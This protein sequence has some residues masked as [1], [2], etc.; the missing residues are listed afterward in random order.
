MN[1]GG[2]G[3]KLADF[4][5]QCKVSFHASAESVAS[6]ERLRS[7]KG[8]ALPSSGLKT[9]EISLRN[10]IA[11][12]LLI[13][14]WDAWAVHRLLQVKDIICCQIC[15]PGKARCRQFVGWVVQNLREAWGGVSQSHQANEDSELLLVLSEASRL[16]PQACRLQQSA[17]ETLQLRLL[18]PTASHQKSPS[19]NVARES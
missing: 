9:P 1:W 15:G 10:T 17:Q 7:Q 18:V 11:Q 2:T 4:T 12:S 5:W 16:R 6:C 3:V 14:S 19:K 8:Q 13:L